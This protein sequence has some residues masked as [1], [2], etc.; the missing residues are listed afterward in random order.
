MTGRPDHILKITK[1]KTLLD[2][3]KRSKQIINNEIQVINK[4]NKKY[5]DSLSLLRTE[6]ISYEESF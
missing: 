5:N 2:S 4:T 3:L 1:I 6:I